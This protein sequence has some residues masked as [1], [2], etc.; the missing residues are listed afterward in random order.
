MI[1]SR[2]T[3][4]LA[5]VLVL[6]GVVVVA[7][8]TFVPDS[9]SWEW[10]YECDTHPSVDPLVWTGSPYVGGAPNGDDGEITVTG[11]GYLRT[12]TTDGWGSWSTNW[13]IPLYTSAG[14]VVAVEWGFRL[15]TDEIGEVRFVANLGGDFPD[16]ATG[17]FGQI[18]I[19]K[20]TTWMSGLAADQVYAAGW[21]TPSGGWEFPKLSL[22]DG[23]DHTA[24]I[25]FT[26][27][28]VEYYID[29]VLLDSYVSTSQTDKYLYAGALGGGRGTTSPT[30][31]WEVDYMRIT[32]VPEPATMSLLGLGALAALIRK[33]R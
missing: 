13:Y 26:D 7:N 11:D 17:Q 25:V 32:N 15:P 16:G 6:L 1:K 30:R 20:D 3:S 19:I 2:V 27:S 4:V 29:G 21:G 9:A 33:R 28:L 23:A 8:A 22:R 12:D 31:T 10:K 24:Q 18:A 5:S 14:S